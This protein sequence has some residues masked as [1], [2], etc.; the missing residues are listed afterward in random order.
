MKIF[1]VGNVSYD[2][3]Y[4]VLEFPLENTKNRLE[5]RVECGGG[6]ASTAAYLL[7]KWGL[8]V[9]FSGVVGDDLYGKRIKEELESVN[10]NTKYLQ[11]SKEI[12]TTTSFI[13]ANKNTGSRT[14]YT[15]KDPLMKLS[16]YELDFNPDII[17]LDGQEYEMSIKLL[18]KYPSALSIIDA[19]R[20]KKE[21]VDLCHRV[22]IIVCS[23]QFAEEIT[24]MNFDSNTY[25]EIYN[26]MKYIFNKDV[27]ITLESK[28]CLANINGKTIVIPSIQVKAIDS[29]GAGDIF[30]GAFT[31]GLVK[32]FDMYNLIRV[33]NIT[34]ALSV[35]KVGGRNSVPTLQEVINAYNES[36]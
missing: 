19:G 21:I 26:K 12:D 2:I 13:L 17:Y 30:H 8:E 20:S 28:G 35:T 36:K 15:Y 27:F 6:P 1:C 18:E 23:K 14:V 31:Y 25:D 22:K 34:G 33:A 29:T 24:E 11:L 10:V 4:P 32:G 16:N 9:Y 3:T 7:G 5:E